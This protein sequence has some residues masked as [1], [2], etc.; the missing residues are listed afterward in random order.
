MPILTAEERVGSLLAG[1]YKLESIL[2]SGGTSVVYRASHA[3]TG[4]S[5]ALK[6]LKP[7]HA[8]DRGLVMRFLREAR[9]ASTIMHP[10]VVAI[11]DMGTDPAG[12]VYLAMELLEGESLG[13][14]L[15]REGTLGVA[16][17]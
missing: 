8:R 1:R 4:K 7:E 12:D 17:T 5:I 9:S 16:R 15:E 14:L 11:H 10:N 13:A 3:W 6:L 2:G